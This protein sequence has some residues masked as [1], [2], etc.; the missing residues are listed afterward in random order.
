[1]SGSSGGMGG[2]GTAISGAA[3]KHKNYKPD[4]AGK[5]K[6]GQAVRGWISKNKK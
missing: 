4:K 1:M 6:L 5:K 2:N 3:L